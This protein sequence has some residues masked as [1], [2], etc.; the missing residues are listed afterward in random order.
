MAF[1]LLISW[2]VW[3]SWNSLL[4]NILQNWASTNYSLFKSLIYKHSI[5]LLYIVS[6]IFQLVRIHVRIERPG[7]LYQWNRV[8]RCCCRHL[9]RRQ[10]WHNQWHRLVHH[11]AGVQRDFLRIHST[12]KW[13][14]VQRQTGWK[15]QRKR[16]FRFFRLTLVLLDVRKR[17]EQ[18][19]ANHALK[20]IAGLKWK[21]NMLETGRKFYKML[22][23]PSPCLIDQFR[24]SR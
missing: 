9:L 6:K 12:S 7:G 19:V 16:F 24:G 10:R 15:R 18:V 17:L 11:S 22:S 3:H 14:L 1:L 20:V 2:I 23:S 13:W 8:L 4:S 21:G 5:S